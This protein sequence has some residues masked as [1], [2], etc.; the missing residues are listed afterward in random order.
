MKISCIC[1]FIV[2]ITSCIDSVGKQ[3]FEIV[4][5]DTD[6]IQICQPNIVEYAILIYY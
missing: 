1:I 6:S 5:Y 2:V 3:N 4:Q